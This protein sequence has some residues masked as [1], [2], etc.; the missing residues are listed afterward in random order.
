MSTSHGP[1]TQI[2]WVTEDIDV[3]EKVLRDEFGAGKWTRLPNI[4]FGPDSCSYRDEPADFAAHISLTYLGD[5]QLELIQPVR[6][7]SIYAEYLDRCG[8]GLHHVCFEPADFDAAVAS[9]KAS[10]IGVVQ[11]GT[12]A[13]SMRFAYLDAAFAGVPYIEFADIGADMRVF[14][15]HV[16]K[17]AS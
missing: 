9:A 15:E 4:E 3:T 17:E 2:A 5:T 6:G 11:Y 8:P 12:M 13:I 16:K 1:I 7:H 10:G 14:F